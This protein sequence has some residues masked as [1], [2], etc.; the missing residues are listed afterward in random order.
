M[1]VV[2]S[3]GDR[4]LSRGGQLLHDAAGVRT[5]VGKKGCARFGPARLLAHPPPVAYG[6]GAVRPG[7]RIGTIATQ[8]PFGTQNSGRLQ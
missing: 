7:L 4:P 3:R 5:I 2:R 1:S 8:K 6:Y